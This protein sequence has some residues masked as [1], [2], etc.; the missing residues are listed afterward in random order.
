MHRFWIILLAVLG[1]DR[2]GA[3]PP[4]PKGA[5][6]ITV[7][8]ASSLKEVETAIGTEWTRRTGQV[9]RL[10]FEASSMLA[11]QIREGAP[12]DIFITAAPEWLNQ[13]TTLERVDWLSNRLVVVVRKEVATFDLARIESLAL[14]DEAVPAGKYAKAALTYMGITLPAR[15]LY[16]ANVRDVLLKVSQGGAQAGVVYVTDAAIDPELRV[17]FTFPPES[18]PRIRYS[19]GL[20]SAPGKPLYDALR[21]PWALEIATKQGFVQLK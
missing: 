7:F 21:Q 9:V 6:P 16:G 12:A 1:C 5:A 13:V 8:A 10:Q 4:P 18:H 15:T 2:G 11:R 17:A 19:V 3:A 20:L 14:A